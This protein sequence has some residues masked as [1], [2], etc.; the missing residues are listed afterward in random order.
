MKLGFLLNQGIQQNHA[1]DVLPSFPLNLPQFFFFFY[2]L[3]GTI[4]IDK[5][6]WISIIKKK[7]IKYLKFFW[8]LNFI[9][10]DWMNPFISSK[11]FISS[12]VGSGGSSQLNV[13]IN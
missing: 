8:Y 4:Y 5:K 7:F 3:Y 9:Y 10:F 11:Y 6:F 1:S 12:S 13:F 2:F